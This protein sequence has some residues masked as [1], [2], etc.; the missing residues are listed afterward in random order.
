MKCTIV[1]CNV[2]TNYENTRYTESEGMHDREVRTLV[3]TERDATG[4][5]VQIT[6]RY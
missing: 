3:L 1:T 2:L 5:Y 6:D 4:T